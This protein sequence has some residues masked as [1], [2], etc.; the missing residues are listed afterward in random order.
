MDY[1]TGHLIF[2]SL[3][4]LTHKI[5]LIIY[6]FWQTHWAFLGLYDKVCLK[7]PSKVSITLEMEGNVIC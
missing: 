1:W 4:L 6:L 3:N 2:L 7:E 5:R